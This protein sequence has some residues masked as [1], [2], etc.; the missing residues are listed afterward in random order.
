MTE[1]VSY[2]MECGKYKVDGVYVHLD[3]P[4]HPSTLTHGYCKPCAG[5]VKER[6]R[7]QIR[8]TRKGTNNG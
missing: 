2:C 3:E 7:E 8:Q 5:V 6:W 4:P 1:Y